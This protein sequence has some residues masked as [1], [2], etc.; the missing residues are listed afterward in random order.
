MALSYTESAALMTDQAFRG[1][2][3]VSC[4][5]YANYISNEGNEVPAH[6]VRLKWAANCLLNPDMVAMQVQ[7]PTVI[8]PAVQAQGASISDTALQS[9]VEDVINKIM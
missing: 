5:N 8:D 2:V 3:K 4:L 7:P 1:R 6:N 9:A